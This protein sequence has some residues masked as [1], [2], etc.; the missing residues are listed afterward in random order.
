MADDQLGLATPLAQP[1]HA[2]DVVDPVPA[3]TA[4]LVS[5]QIR[6]TQ[7]VLAASAA[8]SANAGPSSVLAPLGRLLLP[9]A[10]LALVDLLSDTGAPTLIGSNS[11]SVSEAAQQAA[12]LVAVP[13]AALTALALLG[14]ALKPVAVKASAG[15]AGRTG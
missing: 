2:S 5:E 12:G 3:V 1:D 15:V 14:W 11:E 4:L 7:S 8:E 10:G 13:A 9:P 6:I